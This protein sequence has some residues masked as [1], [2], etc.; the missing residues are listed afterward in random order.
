MLKKIVE[1]YSIL[2]LTAIM[3]VGLALRM[4]NY[5]VWPREGA[6]FDEFAWTFL[7][8][9]MWEK[10]VPTSWSPHKAYTN[11]VEYFNPQGT[12][13][14]LVT[15]Y[16][17]HP[18]LFGL[19]AGGFARLNGV[20]T[21]DEV[22]IAKIRPLALFMGTVA[23][24]AVFLL[25]SAVYGN[26][27]GLIASG[28]YAITPT[29]VVGSR[30]VQNENFFIPLFLFALYFAYKYVRKSFNRDLVMTVVLSAILPLAKVPWV[31]ASVAVIGIF[32]VSKRRKAAL[33]VGVSTAICFS[34]FFLYGYLLDK[35]V[36][37]NLWKLQLARYDMAFDSV[38]SVLRDPLIVDR[39]FVDGWIYFG[40]GAIFLL[41][42]KNIKA[43]LPILFGFLAYAAVFIFAIPNEPLHGWY[44][45]PFYP[46]LAIAI[47]IFLK[48]NINKNYLATGVLII[49]V[50]LSMLAES[51]GKVFGFTYTAYRI[52]LFVSGLSMLPVIYPDKRVKSC[53]YVLQC[54]LIIVVC[55]SM[56]SIVR[57]NEQ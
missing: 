14:T 45:Y 31:A 13:F 36:F 55:L 50:G 32:L 29:V 44:R 7:G 2:V 25:A 10:G 1:K 26:L 5:T 35:Q 46:F 21:F 38:F 48:E 56:W 3:L 28:I 19:I 42:V 33:I 34:G 12:H 49:I 52:F 24:F 15:P 54:C 40:W 11:R 16:L 51:W 57:Y 39:T 22:T 53:S 30:L 27:V 43:N 37:L 6:T 4:H 18:P 47:A 20:T 8:I 17:E 41:L 9:S 23:V